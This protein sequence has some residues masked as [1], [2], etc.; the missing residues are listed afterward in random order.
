MRPETV[1]E[2]THQGQR[3]KAEPP[4]FPASINKCTGCHFHST[5]RAT[6]CSHLPTC[7]GTLR[8]DFRDVIFTPTGA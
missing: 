8:T 5:K 4:L 3:Y 2:F 7:M 1:N 6:G